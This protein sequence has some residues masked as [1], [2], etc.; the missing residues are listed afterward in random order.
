[1]LRS[2]CHHARLG[3][4]RSSLASQYLACFRPFVVSPRG[5]CRGGS[6]HAT[7]GPVV[8]R[9]PNPGIWQ[10]DRWLS[11]VPALP[12]W[13]HAPLSD[14]GGVLD[15]CPS[16]SKTAAFRPLETVGVPRST[17]LRVI[18]LST[19]LPI[20]GLNHAACILV[21][22]SSVR[23]WLGVHV[24]I[25]PALLARLWSGGTCTVS[26]SHPLGNNNQFHG[27]APNSKV[28]GLPW[29][30][31]CVVRRGLGREAVYPIHLPAL[32]PPPHP[33]PQD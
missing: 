27:F 17:S 28:S 22:S 25:T 19:T 20:S 33:A 9:C 2:D 12:L 1:M 31:Q 24:D 14:P 23:P 16:V 29:R 4:L 30:D 26:G 3:S 10:G 5:S 32:E 18:L 13:L 15:T 8:A 6:L 21:P 11:H 7:P